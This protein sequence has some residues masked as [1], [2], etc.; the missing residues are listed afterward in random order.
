MDSFKIKYNVL[1]FP[2]K[3]VDKELTVDNTHSEYKED[4]KLRMRIRWKG[5]LVAFNVGYRVKLSQ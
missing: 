4:G 3:K 2:D 1:F 5:C